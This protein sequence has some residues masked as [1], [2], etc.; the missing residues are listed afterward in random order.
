MRFVRSITNI[1]SVYNFLRRNTA[2]HTFHCLPVSISLHGG[3]G[4]QV[5]DADVEEKWCQD[6]TLVNAVLKAS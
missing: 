2:Q 1:C 6:R 4:W 3:G 5:T